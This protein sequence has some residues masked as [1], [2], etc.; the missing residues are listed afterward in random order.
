MC[1]LIGC[2]G[3]IFPRVIGNLKLIE[4]NEL[5]PRTRSRSLSFQRP[6]LGTL[7]LNA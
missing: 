7:Q 6:M 2:L 3:S 4:E 5:H 1:L